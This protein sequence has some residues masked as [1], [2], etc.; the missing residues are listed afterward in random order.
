[1]KMCIRD[2]IYVTVLFILRFE[3]PVEV[4][5][6][7]ATVNK[8]IGARDESS[9][10]TVSYTHLDVYKRQA[11]HKGT[12]HKCYGHGQEYAEYHRQCFLG[13]EQVVEP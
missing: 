4:G 6:R 9:L 13:V 10:R 1:M 11:L 5:C 12:K 2:S 3:G 8:E 7:C